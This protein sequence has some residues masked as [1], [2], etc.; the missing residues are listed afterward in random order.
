METGFGS[1]VFPL[2][3]EMNIAGSLS[4]ANVHI[5]RPHREHSHY[6]CFVV[7]PITSACFR[8]VLETLPFLNF[9]LNAGMYM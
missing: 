2:A 3:T 4:Y 9:V 6:T 5:F 8:E 7:V 1:F